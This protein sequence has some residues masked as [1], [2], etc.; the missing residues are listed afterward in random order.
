MRPEYQGQGVGR[1][2]MEQIKKRYQD[3]LR[4]ALHAYDQAIG[5]YESCGFSKGQGETPM[6]ITCLHT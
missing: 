4:I 3:Y 5:F 6:Y 1:L 2:L